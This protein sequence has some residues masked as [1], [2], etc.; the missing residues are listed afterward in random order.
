MQAYSKEENQRP[1]TPGDGEK[2]RDGEATLANIDLL[3]LRQAQIPPQESEEE[4]GGGEQLAVEIAGHPD[5]AF[6][7][8][9]REPRR[10]PLL[11]DLQKG[12]QLHGS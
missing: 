10:P 2:W 4:E 7:G 9:H 8:G 3:R 5:E 1:G 11:Q 12:Q 6:E